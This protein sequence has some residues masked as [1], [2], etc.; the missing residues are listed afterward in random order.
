MEIFLLFNFLLLFATIWKYHKGKASPLT[1]STFFSSSFLFS[2]KFICSQFLLSALLFSHMC[3]LCC[4]FEIQSLSINYG[5]G[6]RE[7]CY[8]NGIAYQLL[9]CT[10][11]MHMTTFRENKKI[12]DKRQLSMKFFFYRLLYILLVLLVLFSAVFCFI[13][14]N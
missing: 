7:R 11:H 2:N 4:S 12:Y 14:Y 9:L 8:C 6:K 10:S 3:C 1:H 13:S 5:N